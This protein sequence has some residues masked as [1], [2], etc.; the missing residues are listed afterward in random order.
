MQ[1]ELSGKS[2]SNELLALLDPE[3]NAA[4]RARL[5]AAAARLGEG[6]A[7]IRAAA[8][9]LRAVRQWKEERLEAGD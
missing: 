9:V 5:R 2:L 7:S 8:A 1:D 6:G 3:H 4:T